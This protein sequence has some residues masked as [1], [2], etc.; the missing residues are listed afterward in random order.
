MTTRPKPD[1]QAGR[2]LGLLESAHG[3]KV[4]LPEIL[5]LRISQ[6]SARIHELRHRFGFEIENGSEPGHP[7]HTWFRLLPKSD[8]GKGAGALFSH[9]ELECG[10]AWKDEG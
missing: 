3:R 4:L 9:E 2:I 8:A 7:D 5:N 6:Y 1:S 10:A